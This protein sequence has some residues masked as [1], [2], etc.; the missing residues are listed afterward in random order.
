MNIGEISKPPDDPNIL[1][2]WFQHCFS[3]D[4]F[5][6]QLTGLYSARHIFTRDVPISSYWEIT[7]FI[8]C[9]GG[10]SFGLIC[11]MRN[12]FE[13]AQ[14]DI[15]LTIEIVAACL[16]SFLS[17]FK[18]L[19]IWLYRRELYDLIRL[20]Y[21]RW[22]IQ[23]SRK[24]ITTYMVKNA[25][26]IRQFRI[27]YSIVVAALLTSY[28][29]RP[30][31]AYLLFTFSQSNGSFHF[32]ETVYP[33]HYPFV[34]N[35]AR[36]FFLCIAL[37]TVGIFYLGLYWV[38]ADALFAQLTTHLSIQFQILGN[39][40]RHMRASTEFSSYDTEEIMKG[41]K[42]NVDEY[43]ELFGYVHSLEKIY[44]PILFATVLINGIDLCTC[45]YSLQYRIGE[46]HWGDVGKDAVHASGIALQTLMFCVSAQRL[47]E[48]AINNINSL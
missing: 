12:A 2:S 3:G 21:L 14:T 1:Q 29:V 5:M 26:T 23:V 47:N 38:T 42:R 48:E 22:K 28:V 4:I 10:L 8:F 9:G 31:R 46:S 20:C 36:P 44:N 35:S 34:L 18:G 43:L 39:E 7:P 41:L 45:L 6:L 30:I 25:R 32:S 37:E 19:R 13:L 17:I 16:S 33:A 27:V 40:I 11:D 15:M 24:N